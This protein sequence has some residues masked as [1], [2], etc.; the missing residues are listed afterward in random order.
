MKEYLLPLAIIIASAAYYFKPTEFEVCVEKNKVR[1]H[2]V[3][4]DHKFSFDKYD[5]YN[6]AVAVCSPRGTHVVFNGYM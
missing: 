2:N 5:Q 6:A 3:V 4:L 1:A